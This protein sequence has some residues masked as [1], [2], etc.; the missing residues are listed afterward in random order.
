MRNGRPNWKSSFPLSPRPR[1]SRKRPLLPPS[2][3]PLRPLPFLRR[4]ADAYASARSSGRCADAYACACSCAHHAAAHGRDRSSARHAVDHGRG[5]CRGRDASSCCSCARHRS[6]RSGADCRGARYFA[7]GGG[8]H[9]RVRRAGVH[10]R[11]RSREHH[12]ADWSLGFFRGRLRRTFPTTGKALAYRQ[13]VDKF[14]QAAIVESQRIRLPSAV[15]QVESASKEGGALK[16]NAECHYSISYT[17]RTV[18]VKLRSDSEMFYSPT[19]DPV[20]ATT[21]MRCPL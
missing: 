16:L 7:G 10:A 1:R 13:P 17:S 9:V 12:A 14:A 15:C 3:R 8:D 18:H 4:R 5:R 19:G 2:R 21:L 11:V 6:A 20:L